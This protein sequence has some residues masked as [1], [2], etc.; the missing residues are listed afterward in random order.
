[1]DEPGLNKTNKKYINFS[2]L[3]KNKWD[4]KK[5]NTTMRTGYT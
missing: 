1:M 5:N 4:K 2:S 3:Y